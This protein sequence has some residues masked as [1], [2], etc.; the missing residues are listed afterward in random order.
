MIDDPLILSQI[1]IPHVLRLR[2]KLE[3]LLQMRLEREALEERQIFTLADIAR[4]ERQARARVLANEFPGALRELEFSSSAL[5][6]QKITDLEGVCEGAYAAPVWVVLSIYYHQLIRHALGLRGTAAKKALCVQ[7]PN[8]VQHELA[9]EG[10][11]K[12]NVVIDF[13]AEVFSL[14]QDE[15]RYGIFGE[16]VSLLTT[17]SLVL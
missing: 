10:Q 13:L 14:S 15:I 4:S 7:M 1:E 9:F 8:G 17:G 2:K 5:L 12:P 16:G 3:L 11:H 6:R